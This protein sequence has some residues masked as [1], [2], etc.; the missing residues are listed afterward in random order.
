MH[1]LGHIENTDKTPLYF[2]M[3]SNITIEQSVKT[4]LI[5]GTGNKMAR[6]TVMLSVIANGRK[7]PP[8]MIF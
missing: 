6:M 4:V 7:L 3:P 2:N 5:R 8:Y 1:M